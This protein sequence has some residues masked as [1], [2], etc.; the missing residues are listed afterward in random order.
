MYPPNKAWLHTQIVI[1]HYGDEA[2]KK[3][4]KE[5]QAYCLVQ[6]FIEYFTV[7]NT[8]KWITVEL[9]VWSRW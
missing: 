6:I 5:Q 2:K 8:F 4:Q 7:S 9:Y 3:K 1:V